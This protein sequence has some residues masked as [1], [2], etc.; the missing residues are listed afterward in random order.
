MAK[1]GKTREWVSMECP[2][3]GLRNYRL[4]GLWTGKLELKKYCRICRKHLLHKEKKK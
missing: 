2:E 1:R 4:P 3:C